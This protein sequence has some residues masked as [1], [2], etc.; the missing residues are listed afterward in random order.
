MRIGILTFHSGFNHGAFLQAY[1]LQNA[2][3][4]LNIDNLIIDY[5]NWNQFL[6]EYKYALLNKNLYLL[7]EKIER[8]LKF[9]KVTRRLFLTKRIFKIFQKDFVQFDFILFGSDEIW[10]LNNCVFGFD[11][12]YFGANLNIRKVSYAPSFGSCQPDVM[13]PKDIKRML[14]SFDSISVRDENSNAILKA[15]ISNNTQIVPDPT[16]I[17]NIFNDAEICYEKNYF[18]IYAI[19]LTD[20]FVKK[21]KSY[22]KKCGKK[23][24][25]VG[26]W[27]DWADKNF[28]NISPFQLLGYYMNADAVFTNLFHGTIF[29]I[30][31]NKNFILELS[32]YRKNKFYPMINRLS[33][34]NR[35]FNNNFEE[36]LFSGINYAEVSSR[37][38]DFRNIGISFLQENFLHLNN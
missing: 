17:Y 36:L 1:A 7:K 10:N 21:I 34:E 32:D 33:V 12:T 38:K 9:K 14:E 31:A 22:S 4:Q 15:N 2:L 25:S 5:V 29:S 3:F 18:L 11:S 23:I 27:N 8:V 37:V 30:L 28:I 20:T 26:Y 13:L 24:V 16:F 35:L 19:N 6:N